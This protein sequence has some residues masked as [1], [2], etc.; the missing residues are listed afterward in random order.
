MM[1]EDVQSQ[2][3]EPEHSTWVGPVFGLWL[4]GVFA[5]SLGGRLDATS[6]NSAKLLILLTTAL[7]WPVLYFMF[8]R[9]RFMPERISTGTVVA[10]FTFLLFC[11]LSSFGSPRPF[12]STGYSVL[13]ALA[14]WVVLQFTSNL[15]ASGYERGLKTYA[16]LMCLLVGAFAVYDYVPGVR[17]GNGKDVLNPNTVGLM[18]LSPLVAAMA[19]RFLP[20]RW[21]I[22][23]AMAVVVYLTGSRGAAVAAIGSVAVTMLI[24]LKIVR[25]GTL[26]IAALVLVAGAIA[27]VPYLDKLAEGFDQFFALHDRHRGIET[28]GSG[29]FETWQATWNLFLSSPI[30]GVG[31]RA[32]EPLLKINS[33]SHNGYLA[34]LTEI[35]MFGFAAAV[36]L[37][38]SGLLRLRRHLKQSSDIFAYSVLLGLSCGY[39]LL[40]VVE[41]YFINVG[42]P[43]SLLFLSSIL[44]PHAAGTLGIDERSAEQGDE[45]GAAHEGENAEPLPEANEE[46]GAIIWSI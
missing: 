30:L 39:L 42:N 33:S 26:A 8:S 19:I 7:S 14:C 32:H 11:L 12:D 44:I 18:A 15:D 27:A 25:A 29:R 16:T 24:R 10:L 5:A 22:M 6:A 9:C 17:L 38:V 34:L 41:R 2:S 21:A 13:T 43:T 31:F 37:T 28:G 1:S 35:G 36:T 40:A 4:A 3:E 23:G 46:Q 20:Y 45:G